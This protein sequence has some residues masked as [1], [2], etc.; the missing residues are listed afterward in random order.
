M[1]LALQLEKDYNIKLNE[2]Q[3]I[4]VKDF[5]SNILILAGP[6]AGKTTTILAFL[7]ALIKYIGVNPKNILNLTFSRA[8][9]NNMKERFSETFGEDLAESLTFSTIHS[10]CNTVIANNLRKVGGNFPLLIDDVPQPSKK[11]KKENRYLNADVYTGV[12]TAGLETKNHKKDNISKAQIL[13]QLYYEYNGDYISDEDL[14]L[15]V[16]KIGYYKNMMIDMDHFDGRT[17][18]IKGFKNIF[19]QYDNIKRKNNWMD[20]DDMCLIAYN[21][22]QNNKELLAYYRM[23]YKYINVDEAQDTSLLQHKLIHLIAVPNSRVFMIGDLDQSIYQFRGC[24]STIL[25]NFTK[26]YPRAKVHYL[27]R[28]YRST[29]NIVRT[30]GQFIK[31]NVNRFDLVMK[32][33]NPD[34]KVVVHHC[35]RDAIDQYVFIAESLI[36]TNN[37]FE[38]YAVLYRNN[39]SAIPVADILER[40]NIP[41]FIRDFKTNFFSHRVTLDM[42][43]F[44][45]LA[46]D[47]TDIN[48][49]GQIY[50]KMNGY[51]SKEMFL[52][53]KDCLPYTEGYEPGKK[54]N[55]FDGLLETEELTRKQATTIKSIRESFKRLVKLNPREALDYIDSFMGY[56]DYLRRKQKR[57][58]GATIE[59]SFQILSCLKS[60]ASHSYDKQDF[61]K[62]MKDLKD[63][64]KRSKN[65]FGADVVTLS[66]VHSSKGLEYDIVFLID[67][68]E[69]LFPS[70]K[71]IEE[72]DDGNIKAL[73][74]EA[75]MFYVGITRPR[76]ELILLSAVSCNGNYVC[77]SRF[78]ERCGDCIDSICC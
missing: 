74:E 7:G 45:K 36:K 60:I 33:N 12:S 46:E 65:N 6:G 68:F 62:R 16:N 32:T 56:G 77:T 5:E 49:F 22:L 76:R 78:V 42:L 66:T 35:L 38:E 40:N 13:K 48:A 67:L 44:I 47:P 41:F 4:A 59:G 63:I 2:E 34:G 20:F 61:V 58:N 1:D 17:I 31:G 15:L 26:M 72:S 9:A 27:V 23:K 71:S 29:G 11:N 64:I 70:A 51:L 25:L 54:F 69:G 19:I 73:E 50:Y 18:K 57:D 30:A 3:S 10:F 55:V 43:A 53:L 24:D 14:E 28:N 21:A 39:L 8:A 75:C 52:Y 37:F